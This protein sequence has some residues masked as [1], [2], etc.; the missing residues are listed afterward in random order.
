MS[1]ATFEAEM[2]TRLG[3]GYRLRPSMTDP[4]ALLVEQKIGAGFFDTSLDYYHD[5]YARI[6]DGYTLV[7]TCHQDA[8][9]QCDTCFMRVALPHKRIAEVRCPYCYA[10]GEKSMFFAGYLPLHDYLLETL[11]KTHPRRGWQWRAELDAENRRRVAAVDRHAANNLEAIM[12]E[13]HSSIVGIARSYL[14][15]HRTY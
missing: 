2:Y 7:M 9:I 4:A 13:R 10:R 6:R 12:K 11:E 1:P 14:A 8:S 5:D 15:D 3:P